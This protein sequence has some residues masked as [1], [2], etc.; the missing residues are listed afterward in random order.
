MSKKQIGN[1]GLLMSTDF[2]CSNNG[3]LVV[4]RKKEGR[5][6]MNG[7]YAMSK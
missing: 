4:R 6:A 1:P 3:N 5:V 7:W 2:S